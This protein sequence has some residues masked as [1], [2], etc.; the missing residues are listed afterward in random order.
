MAKIVT[1]DRL[2]PVC[3]YTRQVKKHC[4]FIV[5]GLT[6]IDVWARSTETSVVKVVFYFGIQCIRCKLV[7]ALMIFRE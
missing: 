1:K 4:S 3:I 2:V 7:L 5:W 6:M